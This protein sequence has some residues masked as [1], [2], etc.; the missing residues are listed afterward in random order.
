MIRLIQLLNKLM[1]IRASENTL[2][3]TAPIHGINVEIFSDDSL[4]LKFCSYH[5]GP[6]SDLL[7]DTE[8]KLTVFFGEDYIKSFSN[9]SMTHYGDCTYVG[10]S[11]LHWHNP[12]GFRIFVTFEPPNHVVIY[13]YHSAINPEGCEEDLSRNYI[14]SI[15]WSILYP[16]F[17]ILKN[18]KNVLLLHASSVSVN[19]S[20]LAFY[21]LNKV[22]KSSIAHYMHRSLNAQILSDN[23]ML[24]SSSSILKSPEPIRLIDNEYH[25]LGKKYP[26]AYGKILIPN[27]TSINQKCKLQKF[28]IIKNS[29]SLSCQ[30]ISWESCERFVT[31]AQ[32][33]L[34]E[35]PENSFMSFLSYA[36]SIFE[37][38]PAPNLPKCNTDYYSL[39]VPHG[40]NLKNLLPFFE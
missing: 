19:G 35:F 18:S 40:T 27:D 1:A 10:D 4:F 24:L 39:S 34:S 32:R 26:R 25:E 5:L 11:I 31:M 22:G 13:S 29:A 12:F 15:R 37:S 33:T 28:F 16:I 30:R 21:G 3:Y 14:R 7:T 38:P 9:Q 17:E 6:P 20:G 2:K 36:L 23:F 8:F